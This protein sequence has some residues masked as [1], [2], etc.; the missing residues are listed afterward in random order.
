MMI[1]KI[2]IIL[3]LFNNRHKKNIKMNKWENKN[4]KISLDKYKESEKY[5]NNEINKNLNN[6]RN[7][8]KVIELFYK[9]INKNQIGLIQIQ[10]KHKPHII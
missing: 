2:N 3:N 4:K 1:N 9:K 6:L 10:G 8:L 5:N 7:H